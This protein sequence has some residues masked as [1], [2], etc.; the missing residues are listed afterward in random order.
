MKDRDYHR[1][2]SQQYYH[3][4]RNNIIQD[5][6]GRCVRCGSSEN[7]EI[8]HCDPTKK[9]F[10]IGD[11]LNHSK[12]EV[13]RELTKCQLLCHNCHRKKSNEELQIRNS[14]SGN[15]NFGNTGSNSI[16]SKPTKCIETG[17]I[18]PSATAA[19]MEMN[20]NKSSVERVCKGDRNS[21][22][23]LHFVYVE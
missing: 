17:K 15:P 7:L 6:G 21:Y 22:H 2:Y 13:E 11:L 19:A 14:G 12:E 18:F 16:F 5:L 10:N 8:D 1:A 23:G 4:R 20:L 9:H 3:T